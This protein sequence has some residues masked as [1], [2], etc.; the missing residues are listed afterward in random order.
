MFKYTSFFQYSFEQQTFGSI[1]IGNNWKHEQVSYDYK[2]NYT[3]TEF[4]IVNIFQYINII[5]SDLS[6][7]LVSFIIDV[8]LIVFLKKQANKS[9]SI[10]RAVQVN[11]APAASAKK[12]ES[13]RKRLTWMIV[14]IL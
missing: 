13:I 14:L 6:Y 9:Q 11:N 8:I 7:I 2:E 10:G 12:K 1:T 5:L 4:I 3:P